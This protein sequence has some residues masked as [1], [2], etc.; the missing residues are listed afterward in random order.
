[1]AVAAILLRVVCAAYRPDPRLSAIDRQLAA[2]RNTV[3]DIEAG[4]AKFADAASQGRLAF[5]IDNARLRVVLTRA[6]L[7]SR[8]PESRARVLS[9]DAPDEAPLAPSFPSTGSRAG[10]DP[11]NLAYVLYTSGS[12]GLPKDV[13][14]LPPQLGRLRAR[15]RPPPSRD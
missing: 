2:D 4:A 12:T 15:Q 14:V 6:G 5:M 3:L 7:S 9:L 13:E 8:L 11:Q 1:M 10:L